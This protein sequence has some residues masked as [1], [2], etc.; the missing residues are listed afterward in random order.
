MDYIRA[1]GIP[2]LFTVVLGFKLSCVTIDV[3]HCVD[4]G[5][6]SPIIGNTFFILVVLRACLGG[7]TYAERMQRL[8][9]RLKSWSQRTKCSY[10]VQGKLSLE[11]IRATASEWPKLKAK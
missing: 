8:H 2:T 4:L 6:A 10:R 7:G 3:L 1:R 5:I 9:N 11:R